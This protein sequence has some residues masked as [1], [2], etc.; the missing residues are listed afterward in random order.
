MNQAIE[1][2]CVLDLVI[3]FMLTD[4]LFRRLFLLV[5]E[6]VFENSFNSILLLTRFALD[7][8]ETLFENGMCSP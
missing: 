1:K 7:Y 3:T 6:M 8:Y 5:A 2:Y 4:I